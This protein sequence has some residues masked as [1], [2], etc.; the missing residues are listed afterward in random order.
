MPQVY[1]SIPVIQDRLQGMLLAVV[2][3]TQTQ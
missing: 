1:Q 2:K 3:Q